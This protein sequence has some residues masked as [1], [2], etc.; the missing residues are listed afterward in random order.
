MRFTGVHEKLLKGC[1]LSVLVL[2]TI[3]VYY[4][5]LFYGFIFDD[6]P[7]IVNSVS[8]RNDTLSNL[9]FA[10]S[11]WVVF[12][13]NT[14]YYKIVG[15]EPFL[16]RVGN[17]IIHIAN[18]LLLFTL[19][20]TLLPRSQ[21]DTFVSSYAYQLSFLAAGLFLLHP[22]Q[23]QTI[24][25]TIQGQ[26][27]GSALLGILLILLCYTVY[28][29]GTGVLRLS[30]AG[31]TLLI[32][33][34]SCGTKEIVII[35]PVLVLLI[36]WFFIACGDVKALTSRIPFLATLTVAMVGCFCFLVKPTFFLELITLSTKHGNSAGNTLT[37]Q[38]ET[39]ITPVHFLISQFKV[40]LH[41]LGIFMWPQGLSVD[42]GWKLS[43]SFWSLDSFLPFSILCLL[44][45]YVIKVWYKNKTSIPVFAFLWFF[46]SIL[47]RASII[48]SSELV[49]DYKT[50]QASVGI[51]F[52]IALFL[53]KGT[54]ALVSWYT[55]RPYL[56]F[57][58]I[59]WG[60]LTF[61]VLTESLIA[62]R[63]TRVWASKKNFWKDALEHKQEKARPYNNYAFALL[64]EKKYEEA[65]PYLKKAL[66]IDPHYTDAW[67]NL[68]LAEGSLGNTDK[69][70]EYLQRALH[71]NPGHAESYNN[72]AA[73][74]LSKKDYTSAQALLKKALE[75]KKHYGTAL[76]QLGQISFFQG[77]V[78]EAYEYFKEACTNSDRLTAEAHSCWGMTSMLLHRYYDALKAYSIAVKLRPHD[79]ELLVHLGYAHLYTKKHD[80]AEEI[81]KGIISK[82]KD[83][84]HA[85]L[86]LADV[87]IAKEQYQKALEIY[88]KIEK[89][90][91]KEPLILLR[92]A[93]C[94]YKLGNLPL[95]RIY[96]NRVL[97]TH[98][99]P[100]L[101]ATLEEISEALEKGDT[102][103]K[104]L[105]WFK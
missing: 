70:I 49:V 38:P 69:A 14:L 18:G 5:S 81:F 63:R 50:Y 36:D 101:Q 77:N 79:E 48:P 51:V 53:L 4:Q 31:L 11:R 6:Y 16:Y 72:L 39:I 8:I 33:L 82:H 60:F 43:E 27:E 32:S 76:F 85:L 55:A 45:A 13:L 97:T 21:R 68:A 94:Y 75:V 37:H 25:Y 90:G 22:V 71:L 19:L 54:Q 10:H 42:Y 30:M 26:L 41:Y 88:K 44:W 61:I 1:G 62:Q 46:I 103:A 67:N 7:N 29:L 89:D 35:A 58:P 84:L 20:S 56:R 17:L 73:Y 47:P 15:F 66:E 91:A 34:L 95:A 98:P 96:I 64:E 52:L 65:L 92:M 74:Y 104:I 100:E 9:F 24:C 12:W 86:G 78:V 87:L 80:K 105:K 2:L 59:A 28:A 23:T 57:Y 99:S 40:I 3:V 102:T 83:H 93:G